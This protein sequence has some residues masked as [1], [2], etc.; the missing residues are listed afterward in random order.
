VCCSI[1]AVFFVFDEVHRIKLALFVRLS[2]LATVVFATFIVLLSITFLVEQPKL[3]LQRVEAKN[4]IV[5]SL[6]LKR[7]Q[8]FSAL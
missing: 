8:N 6:A 4:V 7:I 1:Q 2:A 3:R 5:M